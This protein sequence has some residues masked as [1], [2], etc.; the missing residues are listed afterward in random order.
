MNGGFVMNTTKKG[1]GVPFYQA[2]EQC[3]KR[4]AKVSGGIIGVTRKKDAVALD[5][6]RISSPKTISTLISLRGRMT[7]KKNSHFIMI[8]TEV[9]LLYY[10]HKYGT[11][12]RAVSP[13]SKVCNPLQDQTVL[14]NILKRGVVI[15]VYVEKLICCIRECHE[16]YT[17]FLDDRLKEKF[18]STHSTISNC[19]SKGHLESSIQIPPVKRFHY[20]AIVLT[21]M[22]TKAGHNSDEIHIVF[23]DYRED[24][25][26]NG[27]RDRR[28]KSKE[29]V[30]LDAISP[31]QN[32]WLTTNYCD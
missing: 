20:F 30:A 16:A 28:A 14:K 26:K 1:S 5:L 27:E 2:L 7:F 31:N 13:E 12:H 23:D 9:Q 22:I 32:E 4:P 19:S 11:R 29:M 6:W 25:I 24:S 18:L 10:D 3:Y 17:R 21:S 15:N 8:S